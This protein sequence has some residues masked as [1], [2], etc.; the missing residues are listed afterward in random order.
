MVETKRFAIVTPLLCVLTIC[1]ALSGCVGQNADIRKA[2]G[3]LPLS[4]SMVIDVSFQSEYSGTAMQCKAY[5]PKGYGDGREYPVLYALNGSGSDEDMW[6]DAGL[7]ASVDRLIAEGSIAPLILVFPRTSAVTLDELRK[8]FDDDGKMGERNMDL[9][10]CNEVVP[11]V[12]ARFDTVRNRAGRFIC[13]YSMG[14]MVAVR[15]ALHHTDAFGKVAGYSPALLDADYSA[16][17]LEQW[18]NPNDDPREASDFSNLA[19]YLDAGSSGDPFYARVRS[20]HKALVKRGASSEFHP[21][22]GGHSL[23][24]MNGDFGDYLRFFAP[25][26]RAKPCSIGS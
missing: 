16:L 26:P 6:V 9:I 15:I 5:F 21:Y 17:Q 8:D 3:I 20:L 24:H 23:A 19:V 2:G 12:D 18:L 10:I 4:A 25:M 13:G 11:Y 7:T 1:L 22:D 14:G